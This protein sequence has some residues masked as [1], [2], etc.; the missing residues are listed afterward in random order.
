MASAVRAAGLS[1]A[2]PSPKRRWTGGVPAEAGLL[3]GVQTSSSIGA[4][5]LQVSHRPLTFAGTSPVTGTSPVLEGTLRSRADGPSHLAEASW[6]GPTDVGARS[7]HEDAL[8]L[9]E[10]V[11]SRQGT[12]SLAS[13]S[14]RLDRPLRG[15]DDNKKRRRPCGVKVKL[16]PCEHSSTP[17]RAHPQPER[18]L[19]AANPMG[20][21]KKRRARPGPGSPIR[22]CV[23]GWVLATR[24]RQHEVP[25]R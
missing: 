10:R 18:H 12:S 6:R 5:A 17:E 19:T 2:P 13:A 16:S 9:P 3:S 1:P 21:N 4:E 23:P 11:Q 20:P 25:R 22:D 14:G 24:R 15:G 7:V 8:M